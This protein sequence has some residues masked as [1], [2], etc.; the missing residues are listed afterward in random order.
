ML[1]KCD[2]MDCLWAEMQMREVRA[3]KDSDRDK[4]REAFGKVYQKYQENLYTLCRKVCGDEGSA[5]LVY[6][7]TWKKIWNKPEYDYQGYKTTF[8]VWASIIA[9]RI[10]IDLRQKTIL[11]T[12]HEKFP[13]I[14]IEAH[15]YEI[16][17][18]PE[19]PNINE[20]LL[21]EALHQLTEK[22]YDILMTYIEYDTDKKKHVPDRIIEELTAK[23]QTTPVN[24][25]QIKSRSL[26]KVITYIDERR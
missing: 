18:N 25:R 3:Y 15:E 17:E 22:E 14:P 4:A 26:K 2:E 21:E 16:E 5:D 8:M 20:A 7:E 19:L 13:D 1:R 10:W 12:D 9:K 6:G 11:R 23:Y 24:L